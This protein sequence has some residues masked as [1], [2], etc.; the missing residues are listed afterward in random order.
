MMSTG[1]DTAGTAISCKA[2][3]NTLFVRKKYSI[4]PIYFLTYLNK[5]KVRVQAPK[6]GQR[7]WPEMT[8]KQVKRREQ[9][10][11]KSHAKT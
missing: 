6:F 9:R 1:P 2:F 7:R 5:V 3:K 10:E 8:G 11:D 4:Y